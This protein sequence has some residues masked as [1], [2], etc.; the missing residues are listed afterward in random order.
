M[1]GIAIGAKVLG[2]ILGGGGPRAP[3]MCQ[4]QQQQMQCQRP[5]H[6]NC[7]A[8]MQNGCQQVNNCSHSFFGQPCQRM[9][10]AIAMAGMNGSAAFA[11]SSSAGGYGNNSFNNFFNP[12]FD[13]GFGGGFGGPPPF[14]FPGGGASLALGI[15]L[16]I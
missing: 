13:G 14:G 3:R 6:L 11:F 12:G 2:G 8:R 7:C 15:N 1:L 5:A 10:G 9:N 4:Q 16:N